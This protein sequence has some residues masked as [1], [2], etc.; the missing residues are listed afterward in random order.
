MFRTY[1]LETLLTINQG[2][3]SWASKKRVCFCVLFLHGV[4]F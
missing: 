2:L 4:G 1:R 3:L